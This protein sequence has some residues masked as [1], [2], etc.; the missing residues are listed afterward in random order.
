VRNG[1]GQDL[2][3]C[4]ALIDCRVNHGRRPTAG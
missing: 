4:D 2:V 3:L 1:F